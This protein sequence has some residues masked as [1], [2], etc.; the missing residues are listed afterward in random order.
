MKSKA[1]HPKDLL[2]RCMSLRRDGYW[3]AMCIDLDLAVQ[4][5]TAAQ[6]R[7]LLTEQIRSYMADAV[8]TDAEH[9]DTL[10][11]RKAPLRYFVLFYWMLFV[12]ASKRYK[13][14]R[15]ALPL[16]PIGA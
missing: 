5:D 8:G 12:H 11:S 4:A 10:L 1:I 6:A 9:A 16:V 15:S 3:V 7:K 14:Y 2:L 13:S